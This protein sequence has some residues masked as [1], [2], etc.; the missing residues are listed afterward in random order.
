LTPPKAAGTPVVEDFNNRGGRVAIVNY[1]VP[2]DVKAAF[3]AAF[4][5]QNKSAVIAR[6][7]TEAVEQTKLLVR[8]KRAMEALL[9]LRKKSRPVTTAEIRRAR[10]KGR[11]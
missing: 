2:D 3:D 5:G 7:M 6:L 10:I 1:S 4:S 8:R 9:A 11:P